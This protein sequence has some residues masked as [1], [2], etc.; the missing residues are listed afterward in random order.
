MTGIFPVS[1][2]GRLIC[3][4]T[5]GGQITPSPR[6]SLSLR[7]SSPRAGARGFCSP[8]RSRSPGPQ[9]L[10][11][12]VEDGGVVSLGGGAGGFWARH[13]IVIIIVAAMSKAP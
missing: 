7:F 13:G 10:L 9:A 1:G 12:A 2:A 5:S 8:D 4:S 11:S 3:G 6:A